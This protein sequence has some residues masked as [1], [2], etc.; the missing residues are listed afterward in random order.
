LA[1]HLA[2]RSDMHRV[3]RRMGS[4]SPETSIA[5]VVASDR[6]PRRQGKWG[7][8]TRHV[9]L[10]DKSREAR[11]QETP[12]GR[13]GSPNMSPVLANTD[14]KDPNARRHALQR[15]ETR[16]AKQVALY[17]VVRRKGSRR[18]SPRRSRAGAMD[19]RH[20]ARRAG[21][22]ARLTG[23]GPRRRDLL[24]LSRSSRRQSRYPERATRCPRARQLEQSRRLS[25]FPRHS[26]GDRL[27][28]DPGPR[29]RVFSARRRV[30]R[31][32]ALLSPVRL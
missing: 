31:C 24:R 25:R 1:I 5:R 23:A 16:I 22:V 2:K 15:Q 14:D 18:L 30:Q 27:R 28:V 21:V 19:R 26:V 3:A 20:A 17:C 32:R 10:G 8:A 12:G 6:V 9:C 11:R 7:Q 29:C 13:R 4:R